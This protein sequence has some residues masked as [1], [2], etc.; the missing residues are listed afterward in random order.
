VKPLEKVE[1][2]KV[3]NF[4]FGSNFKIETDFQFDCNFKG[5]QPY[6]KNHRNSP[7][8]YLLKIFITVNLYWPTCIKKFEVPLQVAIRT[9]M[10]NPKRVQFE[11]ENSFEL[12]FYCS[13]HGGN[14][15]ELLWLL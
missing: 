4:P 7:K 13:D 12:N 15:V 2:M 6:R 8:F 1:G 5:L 10:Q 11:F 3:N 9:K 14:T